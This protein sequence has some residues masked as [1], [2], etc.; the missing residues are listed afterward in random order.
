MISSNFSNCLTANVKIRVPFFDLDPANVVWH[1]RYFQYFELARCELLESV[2]YSYEGMQ[3]SGLLWPVADSVVR[4]VRPLTLN[5]LVSVTACLREWEMR[6]V[7]DYKIEDENGAILTRA[8]T[9]Q[10]P[11]DAETQE[12]TLGAPQI[13]LDNVDEKLAELRKTAG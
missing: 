8:R 5:Q 13:L 9:I 10:V 7:L 11:V 12:L 3:A 2:G 1:G 4:Y 6:L